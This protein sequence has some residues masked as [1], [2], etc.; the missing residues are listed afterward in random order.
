MI[1]MRLPIVKQTRNRH[2]IAYCRQNCDACQDPCDK[3]GRYSKKGLP[4]GHLELSIP[5][6]GDSALLPSS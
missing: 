2:E 4:K 3:Q 5:D 1:P 6:F